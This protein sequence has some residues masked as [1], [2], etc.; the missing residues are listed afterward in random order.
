MANIFKEII[1]KLHI[2]LLHSSYWSDRPNLAAREKNGKY[3][4]R[5]LVLNNKGRANV[6]GKFS[7]LPKGV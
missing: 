7:G 6:E 5:D 3:S 2:S 4:L 1:M